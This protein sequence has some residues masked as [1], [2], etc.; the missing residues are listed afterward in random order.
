MRSHSLH[1]LP[2]YCSHILI[3]IF[4]EVLFDVEHHHGYACKIQFD[5]E[6]K[7]GPEPAGQWTI[8]GGDGVSFNVSALKENEIPKQNQDTWY[9]RPAVDYWVAT[10][11][12]YTNGT[13]EIKG[14]DVKCPL[15]PPQGERRP[16]SFLLTPFDGKDMSVHWF[17][18]Y[19][20]S[21]LNFPSI[22]ADWART[23]LD[24]PKTGITMNLYE[25][26]FD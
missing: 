18:K 20:Y 26:D 2:K 10:I 7:Q 14:G 8:Q 15:S 21:W 1:R 9:N 25:M 4:T 11:T 23:E 6:G 17:G 12:I 16:I 13:Y 5:L 3:Q 19:R 24:Y 22:L